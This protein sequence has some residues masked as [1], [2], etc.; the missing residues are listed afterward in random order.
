MSMRKSLYW[1]ALSV[2]YT[3]LILVADDESDVDILCIHFTDTFT[4][5][6]HARLQPLEFMETGT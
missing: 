2:N 6:L 4:I 1:R 5:A 3:E